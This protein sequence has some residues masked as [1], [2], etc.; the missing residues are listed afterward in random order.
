MKTHEQKQLAVYQPKSR[1]Q[2]LK[3]HAG[4]TAL[5]ISAGV[6][7]APAFAGVDVTEVTSEISSN[8]SGMNS[9]GLA[10]LGLLAL[11]VGF[12]MVRRLMR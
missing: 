9:V 11:V 12:M 1:W 6:M 2:Q 10:V 8:K 7:S 5:A 4:T 3:D